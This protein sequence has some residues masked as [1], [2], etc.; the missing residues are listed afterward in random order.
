MRKM[1]RRHPTFKEDAV[2]LI[3]LSVWF[4]LILLTRVSIICSTLDMEHPYLRRAVTVSVERFK[5]PGLRLIQSSC[6]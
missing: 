5:K 2:L 1:G 6:H 3:L 4:S